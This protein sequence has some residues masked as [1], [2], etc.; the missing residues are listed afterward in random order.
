MYLYEPKEI[1]VA[2]ILGMV[3]LLSKGDE[4]RKIFMIRKVFSPTYKSLNFLTQINHNLNA[5]QIK[6][7]TSNNQT[8]TM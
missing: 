7:I 4:V 5:N 6:V 1:T 2:P 8:K 3:R